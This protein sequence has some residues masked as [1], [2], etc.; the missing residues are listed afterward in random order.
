MR[1]RKP[2]TASNH[3][4]SPKIAARAQRT[5]QAIVRSP[6]DNRLRLVAAGSTESPPE[7]HDDSKQEAPNVENGVGALQDDLS[8]KMRDSNQTKGFSLATANMQAY[9]AMLVEVTQVNMRFAF[10]FSQRLATTRSPFELLGVITEFTGR[11]IIMLQKHSKELA[12]FWRADV[13]RDV[14]TLPE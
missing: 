9:Q 7:R 6:K 3:A 2:A 4:R 5:K 8:H 10:E 1:N 11:L 13:F 14:A 12:A